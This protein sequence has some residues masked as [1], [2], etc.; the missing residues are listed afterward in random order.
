MKD[1]RPGR[2]DV[3]LWLKRKNKKRVETWKQCEEVGR[4]KTEELEEM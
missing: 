3:V 4:M 2:T 1:I